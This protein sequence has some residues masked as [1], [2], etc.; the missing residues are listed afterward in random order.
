M[1]NLNKN[2]NPNPNSGPFYCSPKSN[3]SG[4]GKKS[5]VCLDREG[6]IH[7]IKLYNTNFPNNPIQSS[8]LDTNEKLVQKIHQRLSSSCQG[9]GDWCWADQS[10]ALTD[11]KIQSYYKPKMPDTRYQ[12][13]TTTDIDSVLQP[14]M[15]I[16]PEFLY[17]GAVPLDFDKLNNYRLSG[18]D[19]CYLYGTNGKS[20]IGGVFNLD[21]HDKR[22]SHWV[23]MFCDLDQNFIAFFDSAKSNRDPP[24]EIKNLMHNIKRQIERCIHH[25]LK[26]YVAGPS[27]EIAIRFNK[28]QKQY[29]GSECGVFSCQYIL[30]CLEGEH[31]EEIFND[32]NFTDKTVNFFRGK[33]FRPSIHSD[34]DIFYELGYLK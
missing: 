19:Y 18:K 22:G 17:L 27:K 11:P 30:R 24:R 15:K 12:W 31:P 16:Y 32:P 5:S 8:L 28:Q 14:Y 20:K 25:R 23:S 2:P 13:L 1:S 34:N 4:R 9:H 7:Y 6:L 26:K 21:T 10:Y 3:Q 29:G 33:I